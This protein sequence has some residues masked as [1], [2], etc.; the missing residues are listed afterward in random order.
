[1]VFGKPQFN[2]KCFSRGVTEPHQSFAQGLRR[3]RP[4]LGLARH[5]SGAPLAGLN[6][7]HP[8][9][10]NPFHFRRLQFHSIAF[11]RSQNG[12]DRHQ[13]RCPKIP[14][15]AMLRISAR[16]A[17]GRATASGQAI[18]NSPRGCARASNGINRD[19]GQHG[20]VSLILHSADFVPERCTAQNCPASL[21]VLE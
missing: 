6:R 13:P 17:I 20:C 3:L 14:E 19:T 15:A 8:L 7:L 12:R 4:S 21:R 11:R 2:R 16:T 10:S 1:M 5:G 18:G 9:H